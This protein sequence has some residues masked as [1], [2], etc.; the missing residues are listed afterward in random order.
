[1]AKEIVAP[2][3]E[4]ID[5]RRQRLAWTVLLTSL[6]I[7]LLLAI[8]IPLWL[9]NWFIT[10]T[11]PQEATLKPISGTVLVNARGVES[12]EFVVR[13]GDVIRTD[14]NSRGVIIFFD[15]SEVTVYPNAQ[16]QITQMRIPSFDLSPR[17]NAI[18]LTQLG[19]RIRV[20]TSAPTDREMEWQ[21]LTPHLTVTF[22]S[23]SFGLEVTDEE[24]EVT[25]R[26]GQ[27]EVKSS[28]ETMVLQ[29]GQRY[30]LSRTTGPSGPLPAARDLMVNGDFADGLT[31]WDIR[32][33]AVEG[34]PQGQV[35]LISDSGRKAVRLLREGPQEHTE[36]GIVQIINLDISD[37]VA[38]QL[39]MDV[40]IDF[41]DLAGGGSQSSEY[42]I[43]VRIDYE[44]QY[45]SPAHWYHGFYT[46]NDRGNP[47]LN[48]QLIPQGV[49]FPYE[50]P[51]LLRL[52]DP[53]PAFIHSIQIYASGWNYDALVSEV[54]LLV[55]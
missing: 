31:N 1:M 48:G 23:G 46:Q 19:G 15:G 12:Q 45:G 36:A 34:L 54:G 10:S 25:V 14:Q 44:D 41:H 2:G 42:P 8:A 53:P 9:R 33:P 51:N 40:R 29:A 43:L 3:V 24:T 7:F 52:M 47:T 21:V 16:V 49:W 38:L 30:I 17:P 32:P 4:T 20:V 13:E 50:E 22:N 28:Q 5:H 35:M 18:I 6:A 39:R 27:A 11:T 37:F 26:S 55:E